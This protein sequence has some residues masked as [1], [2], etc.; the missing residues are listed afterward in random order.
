MH[1]VRRF[2]ILWRPVSALR[3]LGRR[4]R[5]DRRGNYSMI[6]AIL[7]PVITGFVAL[8]TESGLWLYDQQIEQT[9]ADNAAFSAAVYYAGQGSNAT[10]A[11]LT[12]AQIQAAAVAANYG[13]GGSV[14]S[15][16]AC[17]VTFHG[18]TAA[19]CSTSSGGAS[20]SVTTPGTGTSCVQINYPPAGGPNAGVANCPPTSPSNPCFIEVMV[21]QQ[22][23]QLFS[24]VLLSNPVTIEARAV[25]EVAFASGS[26]PIASNACV[27]VTDTSSVA[28][29]ATIANNA[30]ISAANCDLA[31]NDPN[32]GGL[33][34]SGNAQA[35]FKGI[36]DDAPSIASGSITSNAA[37]NGP[38]TFNVTTANPYNI[39]GLPSVSS[40]SSGPCGFT[41]IMTGTFSSGKNTI[42]GL[43]ST[44]AISVGMFAVS[45]GFLSATSPNQNVVTAVNGS[46]QVTLA[47]NATSTGSNELVQFS[48]NAGAMAITANTTLQP[49]YYT[50]INALN[51]ALVN[52]TPGTYYICP[53]PHTVTAS[54]TTA[55]ASSTVVLPS[56][57]PPTGWVNGMVISDSAGA[58]PANTIISSISI[59][60]TLSKDAKTKET[61]DTFSS[62]GG[63]GTATG[64]ITTT[65]AT[66]NAITFTSNPMPWTSGTITDTAGGLASS[67][68]VTVNTDIILGTNATSAKTSD[69]LT[70]SGAG[71]FS[72]TGSAVFY[73]APYLN[74]SGTVGL[75]SACGTN[76]YTS[77][78]GCFSSTATPPDG[79]T[80]VLLGSTGSNS[81]NGPTDCASFALSN[82]ANALLVPPDTSGN[83]GGLNGI[84]I[85]STQNCN[86]AA[87][88]ATS[89]AATLNISG[90]GSLQIFGAI[91]LGQYAVAFGGNG[92]NGN[93]CLQLIAH[94]V[95]LSGNTSLAQNCTGVGTT[96]INETSSGSTG[97][98][99]AALAN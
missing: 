68:T 58:I 82:G 30:N 41:A 3:R 11:T 24:A 14:T 21:A 71:E 52:L 22:P 80:I 45:P 67:T 33:T 34:A 65:T 96:N 56:S 20:C 78:T 99:S 92:S 19:A 57:G 87:V 44:S 64:N 47:T 16:T 95:A 42:T 98:Y 81:G 53:I 25:G 46:T 9:A 59:F 62:T 97:T 49:G 38:T 73:T 2:S 31:V 12:S 13:F 76:P 43:S 66:S 35:T 51:S 32:T 10:T 36:F 39:T 84:V 4:L 86:P 88:G 72:G 6:V 40:A 94:T 8:G 28:G 26:S 79:V 77:A 17:A 85:T 83:P 60:G 5:R 23:Q 37:V 69:T 61:S 48:V 54:G 27:L 29:A 55:S 18:V 63:S 75:P 74:S 50:G 7:L 93:G 90:N 15:T 70:V 1:P 91:D 89:G